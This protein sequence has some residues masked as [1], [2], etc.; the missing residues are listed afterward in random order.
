MFVLAFNSIFYSKILIETFGGVG[1][2]NPNK[3]IM[4]KNLYIILEGVQTL[5]HAL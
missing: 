1:Q 2:K 5:N 3:K 4:K